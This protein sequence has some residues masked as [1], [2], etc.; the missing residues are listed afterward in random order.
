MSDDDIVELL[1]DR[2][3]ESVAAG[4]E[5][6]IEE[7]CR[8]HPPLIERVRA[9]VQELKLTDWMKVKAPDV[10]GTGDDWSQYRPGD[11][12]SQYRPGDTIAGQ[13]R[14][15]ERL[16]RGGHGEVW[17]GSRLSD[18]RAV[19]LKVPLA[20]LVASGEIRPLLDEAK[21][22][23]RLTHPHI[24]PIYY[25]DWF[26]GSFYIVLE[27]I[28]GETL[29]DRIARGG[30]SVDEALRIVKDIARPPADVSS[31]RSTARRGSFGVTIKAETAALVKSHEERSR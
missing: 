25:A 2:W 29:A 3:E 7:L 20:A 23:A 31:S 24:V 1:L 15:E 16:G 19:A 22:A 30:L 13:F 27:L 26:D 4:S 11:D 17:R 28:V 12:G 8:D 21:K 14:L 6:P 18:G 5:I 9:L 10:N